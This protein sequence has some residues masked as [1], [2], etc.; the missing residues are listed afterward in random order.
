MFEW[1]TGGLRKRVRCW[2]CAG[3]R[4]LRWS[5][6]RVIC[7]AVVRARSTRISGRTASHMV[8]LAKGSKLW[9]IWKKGS[10]NGLTQNLVRE[11]AN[12]HGLVD[13]KICSVN[14]QWSGMLFAAEKG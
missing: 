13:Y 8:R 14:A 6:S 5:L 12:E 9:M 4:I 3:L 1:F 10:T 11:A 7:D 2:R